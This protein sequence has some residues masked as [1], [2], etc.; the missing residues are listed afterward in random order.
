[1]VGV[2]ARYF[3]TGVSGA[4][5]SRVV[6]RIAARSTTESVIGVDRR[7]LSVSSPKLQFVRQDLVENDV[8]SWMDSTDVVLHLA[9]SAEPSY[10]AAV[11]KA[12]AK[13]SV[14]QVVLASS[15]TAFGAWPTN[16]VP[17]AED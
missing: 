3:V 8:A 12:A 1:M 6:S 16:S 13:H 5:G 4:L 7:P 17:L 14:T 15:A 10:F 9:S 2:M 11:L